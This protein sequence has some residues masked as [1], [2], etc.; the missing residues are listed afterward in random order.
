MNKPMATRAVSGCSIV[1]CAAYMPLHLLLHRRSFCISLPLNRPTLQSSHSQSFSSNPPTPQFHVGYSTSHSPSLVDYVM[2]ELKAMRSRRRARA[3]NKVELPCAAELL[4]VK[5]AKRSLQKGCLLQ[6]RKD[7]QKL[8]L[9]VAQKPD[10]KKNWMVCDQN[11]VVSSIKPQQITYIVSSFENFDYTDIPDF[12]QKARSLLDPTILE[13]AWEELLENKRSVTPE[14]LAEIIYGCS[15]PLESYCAHLLLSEDDIYFNQ[16]EFKGHASVYEPRPTIQILKEMGLSKTSSSALNLLINIGYFPVH[17]NLDLLKFNIRAEQSEQVLLAAEDLLTNSVDVDEAIRKDL[18]YLKVY[19]IDVDEPDELDDALSAMRLPDGR[20]KVWIH[21]ADPTCLVKPHSIIDREAM[22]NGTSIFLPTA[23]FSMFPEKLAMEGM[24]LQ[25]GKLCKAVSVS[26]TLQEDG[27]IADYTIDNSIIRPTY[28]LT[29]ESA[30]ELLYLGLEEE[31]ELRTLSEAASLRLQW[32]RNQGAIDTS[33]IE[34]RVKV[35]NPDVPEPSINLYAEDQSDP[36][37]RLVS[38]MMILC[39]EVVATFGS[40]HNIP[41]PYRGQPQSS[42][43]AFAFSHLPEG[44]VRSSAYVR[45][46][47]AAEM[48]FNKPIRHGVLGI[49]GYVQFTSPIRRYMDLLAHYQI[50]SFLRGESMPFSSGELE[51]IHCLVDMHV[52]VA[53]KLQN[54]SLRYWLLEYFRRQP[55][56]RKFGALIL[57]FIKDRIASLL[58]VEAG[59]QACA[60]VSAGKQ[61][62]DEIEVFIEEAHPRDDILSVREV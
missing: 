14:E 1:R 21:V 22:Q 43:S 38:E 36:A 12:I 35:V 15:E 9:A 26:V 57:R 61:I 29:Y 40:V 49:P 42:I 34:S 3:T 27:S 48:D 7:S 44:P 52:K 11:G 18:S 24:S 28:M 17:V 55:R 2:E 25:Q 33:T 39:G 10:G 45:I 46:M 8:L 20:I 60:A 4:D 37:M 54:S 59:I 51:G 13:C 32:R 5:H 53:K 62:G 6:F 56:E 47:R 23:T 16:V 31:S 58:L 50:K 41:L 19:A 30:S